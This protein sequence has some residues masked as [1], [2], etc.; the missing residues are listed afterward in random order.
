MDHSDVNIT[1][2]DWSDPPKKIV[3]ILVPYVLMR[4]L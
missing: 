3:L 1:F 4:E 2:P